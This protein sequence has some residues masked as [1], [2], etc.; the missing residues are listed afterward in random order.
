MFN[1][2]RNEAGLTKAYKSPKGIFVENGDTMYVA[3]T[4]SLSDAWDDLKIPLRRTHQTQRFRDADEVFGRGG[5]RKIVGHS[6][7][8]AVALE[9][10]RKNP[11]VETE[12]YGAPVFSNQ[13]S[14]QRFC[15]DRD[16]V[17]VFDKGAKKSSISSSS[18]LRNHT[19]R[20]YS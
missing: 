11:D 4:R 15:R 5:I 12:T 9:F 18:V 16:P 6:L 1:H 2:R 10:L 3:G 7:G 19:Y 8:G 13:K 14:G 17:C 20:G